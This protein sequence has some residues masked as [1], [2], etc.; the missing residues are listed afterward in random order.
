M[1]NLRGASPVGR[2]VGGYSNAARTEGSSGYCRRRC[3]GV[4]LD[5]VE[6]RTKRWRKR[7]GTDSRQGRT[8]AGKV[9]GW[10]S[11]SGRLLPGSGPT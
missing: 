10:A 6:M 9:P 3:V 5:L 8:R 7:I 2:D 4:R 11:F 1:P